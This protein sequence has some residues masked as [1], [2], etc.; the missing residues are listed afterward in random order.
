MII[1]IVHHTRLLISFIGQSF[2][3]FLSGWCA[4]RI[5]DLFGVRNL[6]T[7]GLAIVLNKRAIS[8]LTVY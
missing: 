2:L 4:C 6:P 7:K 3:I 8:I 5:I 1:A